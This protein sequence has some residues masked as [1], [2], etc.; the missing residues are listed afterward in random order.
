M[1]KSLLVT[2]AAG[3]IGANFVQYWMR[4]HPEDKVV[5]YDAQGGTYASRAWWLLRWLGHEA[6]AVLDGGVAAWL[7]AGGTLDAAVPPLAAGAPYPAAAP[8]MPIIGT[9]DLLARLG[10]V[11]L[12]DARAGERFR[13]ETEP[14]DPVAGHIPSAALRFFRD[15]LGADGRFKPAGQLR[16]EFAAKAKEAAA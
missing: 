16:D 1:A 13:G 15:N 7:A 4:H 3:F 12:L 14:L 6:V 2:G 9:E 5:A 11:P 10:R 8:S